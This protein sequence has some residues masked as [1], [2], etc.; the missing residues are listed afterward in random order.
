MLPN[1]Q[2]QLMIGYRGFWRANNGDSWVAAK[3]SDPTGTASSFLGQQIEARL[4]WELAANNSLLEIGTA[5]IRSGKY[6]R[7]T[8]NKAYKKDIFYNYLQLSFSF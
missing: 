7:D 8:G 3:I 5:Y 4:R 2:S 1:N 6:A